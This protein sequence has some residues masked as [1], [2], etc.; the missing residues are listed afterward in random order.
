[1]IPELGNFSLML[2]LGL[3]LTL[4]ILPITGSFL[5]KE[6]WMALARP[7]AT[8]QFAFITLA[9]GCLVYSFVANDFSVSYVAS[10]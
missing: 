4:G 1:M 10:N 7:A 6:R 8:G 5:G 2:A 3:A 9:F